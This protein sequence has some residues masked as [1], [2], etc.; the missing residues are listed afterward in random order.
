MKRSSFVAA[1]ALLMAMCLAGQT[2]T[3]TL[4][5]VVTDESG[6]AVANASVRV[7]N[8]NTNE[9]KELQ[10]DATGHYVVPFLT[11][12][13]YTAEIEAKGFSSAKSESIKIDV[14]QNR[15]VDFSLKVGAL[16]E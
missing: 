11:P 10:T 2:P 12:G 15:S 9:T 8:A 14:G 4:Q 1:L 5:G 13:T 6:A 16:T 7:T 3:G